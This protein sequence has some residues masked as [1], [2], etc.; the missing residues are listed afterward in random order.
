MYCTDLYWPPHLCSKTDLFPL[1]RPSYRQNSEHFLV[2]F[3]A[4][5]GVSSVL[6][7]DTSC[8]GSLEKSADSSKS[9]FMNWRQIFKIGQILAPWSRGWRRIAGARRNC[10][11][12]PGEIMRM[13]GVHC[14]RCS[15]HLHHHQHPG[16]FILPSAKLWNTTM[17]YFF[18]GQN[19]C[20]PL[21]D[22]YSLFW[23]KLMLLKWNIRQVYN[24][25]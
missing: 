24:T 21:D 11:C 14:C 2:Q 5:T 9:F 4:T 10:S 13:R 25:I 19:S 7:E 18:S 22:S 15:G 8:S 6:S 12:A 17:I 1:L 3:L 20:L 16:S 23:V